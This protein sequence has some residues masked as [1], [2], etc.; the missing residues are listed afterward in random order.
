MYLQE[1]DSLAVGY[2]VELSLCGIESDILSP[3]RFPRGTMHAQSA[4]HPTDKAVQE[5]YFQGP[6]KDIPDITRQKMQELEP[7]GIDAN[8]AA[9]KIRGLVEMPKGKRPQRLH[10]DPA[11]DGA[12]IVDGVKGLVRQNMYFRLGLG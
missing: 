2:A 7:E 5:E 6:Y 12:E 4:G 3:G 1:K 8:I 10:V 11:H 9:Q